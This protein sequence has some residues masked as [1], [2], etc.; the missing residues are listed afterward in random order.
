[1]C[2]VQSVKTA[3]F[4]F[5]FTKI[6]IFFRIMHK[7]QQLCWYKTAIKVSKWLLTTKTNKTTAMIAALASKHVQQVL[8][9][10][11]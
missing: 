4:C 3:V 10:H 5:F 8:S 6:F 11:C 9:L 7:K 2:E 1:M